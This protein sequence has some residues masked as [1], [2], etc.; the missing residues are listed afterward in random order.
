MQADARAAR[1]VEDDHIQFAGIEFVHDTDAVRR[2]SG[3]LGVGRDVCG[4]VDTLGTPGDLVRL[5]TSGF[6]FGQHPVDDRDLKTAKIG[7]ANNGQG[8]VVG[9]HA[10]GPQ[11]F[12]RKA[13]LRIG[14]FLS[15]FF[16]RDH[17]RF[18]Q[19]ADKHV[20]EGEVD[21]GTDGN[22]VLFRKLLDHA[23][24]GI[25]QGDDDFLPSG[26]VICR[27]FDHSIHFLGQQALGNDVVHDSRE[28][29][30]GSTSLAGAFVVTNRTA[31]L[32]RRLVSRFHSRFF[33]IVKGH[34]GPHDVGGLFSTVFVDG[35]RGGLHL[36]PF[37]GALPAQILSCLGQLR[38]HCLLHGDAATFDGLG[39]L[40]HII[41]GVLH[42][43]LEIQGHDVRAL[44]IGGAG[45]E[46]SLPRGLQHFAHELRTVV[47][48]IGFFAGGGLSAGIVGFIQD[49]DGIGRDVHHELTPEGILPLDGVEL[50][51]RGENGIIRS[52]A[53]LHH[54]AQDLF[55]RL[56]RLC[57]QLPSVREKDGIATR[58]A[59]VCG[60]GVESL[61]A[62]IRQVADHIGIK[63]RLHGHK[64]RDV[65]LTLCPAD[66]AG[67]DSALS[68]AGLVA[69]N[70][71]G[72]IGN[73]ADGHAQGVHLLG[74]KIVAELCG[75]IAEL[76]RH[77]L[78]NAAVTFF[79]VCQGLS[80]S[81]SHVFGHERPHALHGAGR[82]IGYLK[83]CGF[84]LLGSR[85]LVTGLLLPGRGA[86]SQLGTY[87]PAVTEFAHSSSVIS[88]APFSG[89]SSV[90]VCGQVRLSCPSGTPAFCISRYVISGFASRPFT[91]Q[92]SPSASF[93]RSVIPYPRIEA[94]SRSRTI[95]PS[96]SSGSYA[97][98][99]SVCNFSVSS[100]INSS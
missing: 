67:I 49:E 18:F 62:D 94:F 100:S 92:Y 12:V 97:S 95:C 29:G 44:G 21:G 40:A 93:R 8:I 6:K 4:V 57:F 69:N 72:T 78:V 60:Q 99:I 48:G 43:C 37:K 59:R 75:R 3:T 36:R 98:S 66:D 81:G 84:W 91:S 19:I 88:S 23:A 76:I 17:P 2:T 46:C 80:G 96:V 10:V 55:M 26:H 63:V 54:V 79:K 83:F 35:N 28:I 73:I 52:H 90:A 39:Q 7:V 64:D 61:H 70:E 22:A 30:A 56:R 24:H 15:G 45:I 51:V 71:A 38:G 5:D 87:I 33:G 82:F 1:L 41:G 85:W 68:D 13:A 42:V 25:G 74:G 86:Y 53:V 58:K 27:G 11:L 31:R 77:I 34:D 50:V 32:C 14:F 89:V 9:L 16:D 65:A 20:I 47:C